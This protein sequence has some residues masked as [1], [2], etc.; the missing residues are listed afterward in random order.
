MSG[1]WPD[2]GLGAGAAP[3]LGPRG[4]LLFTCVRC[5]KLA[6]SPERADPGLDLVDGRQHSEQPARTTNVGSARSHH[7]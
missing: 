4:V 7:R 1:G 5:R 6:R 3:Q 2:R